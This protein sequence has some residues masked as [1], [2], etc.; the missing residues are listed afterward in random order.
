[1]FGYVMIGGRG[2]DV[3]LFVGVSKIFVCVCPCSSRKTILNV[4]GLSLS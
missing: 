4:I 2:S 1:M 3:F